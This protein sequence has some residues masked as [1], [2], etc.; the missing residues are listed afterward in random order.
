MKVT[1]V[2]V[3][4]TP[5]TPRRVA[6]GIHPTLAREAEELEEP[7]ELWEQEKAEDPDGKQ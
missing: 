7:E 3:R 5:G 4:G 6:D 1:L 2:G